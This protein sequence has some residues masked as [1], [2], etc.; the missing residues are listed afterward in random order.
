MASSESRHAP[1]S[2]CDALIVVPPP[3]PSDTNPPLG[4]AILAT[5]AA[6]SGFHVEVLDLNILLLR[7]FGK[8]AGGLGHT[9]GDHGKDRSGVAAAAQWLFA[10]TGLRG[11]P[12]LHLPDTADPVA[13][14]HYPL[15]AVT[16]A[17]TAA[18]A[19]PE[20]WRA[21]LEEHLLATCDRPPTV[22]GVSLMGPS[23]VFVGLLVLRVV[24]E[25]WPGTT[26]VLGGSHVTL[27]RES[28]QRD[29]GLRDGVDLVL[30]GHCEDEFVAMVARLSARPI[31]RP[32][33]PAKPPARAP[34]EY[35]PTFGERQLTHYDRR[36][37]TLPVQFTRGCSYGR[38]TFCTYP[39]V[40]PQLTALD[41]AAASRTMGVLAQT[42]GIR[43]FS[44]KD[45]L[46]TAPM[47]RALAHALRQTP[48]TD[49]RWSA[50]T[51][52]SRA[53]VPIAP[54]LAGSGLATLEIGVETISSTGQRLFDKRAD[55]TMLQEL[56]LALAE[57]GI[58][59]VTNLIF[60]FPGER[61]EEAQAQ[62]AWFL[63]LQAAASPGRVDCSLNMLEMVRGA[64][65]VAH[66]PAGVEL[67]GV[68]PWAF[69]YA[70]NAPAWRRDFAA[71]LERVERAR[72]ATGALTVAGTPAGTGALSFD[73]APPRR[74]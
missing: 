33:T 57:A 68:A 30:T 27:L 46:F 66:P 12:P 31:R 67:H 23:Q 26:T 10:H 64:P 3:S 52:A 16:A 17:V 47:L 6:R 37:V 28:L 60:G 62:L 54:L 39:V 25:I 69:S 38:C 8:R 73:G 13:G 29:A 7:Q 19:D 59:V 5:V 45:S 72:G 21:W 36:Q 71:D 4:P 24:K 53:L 63:R 9:L 11:T 51:K 35:L 56:I 49:V 61:E 50:T 55:P 1:L 42:Y 34:F 48:A 44:V 41:V 15:S 70:W 40:E 74:S 18:A 20:P 2:R 22:V 43:R 32:L 58:T 14:M 65:M